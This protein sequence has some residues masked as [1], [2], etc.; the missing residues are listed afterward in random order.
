MNWQIFMNATFSLLGALVLVLAVFA[1][2][3]VR[4]ATILLWAIA[5][6]V[7]AGIMGIEIK[8]D[9]IKAALEKNDG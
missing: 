4:E 7:Q 3:D 9:A 2:D 5:M 6:F 8:L 1:S